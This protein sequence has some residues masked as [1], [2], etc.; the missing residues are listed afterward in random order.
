MPVTINP[1]EVEFS[2]I[3]AQGPGGQNV[4]K[5]SCAVHAR[6]DIA[7]SSLPQ[8]IKQRML[9][10]RDSRITEDGVVVIKAQQSRSLEQ[11]KEDA[12]NRLQQLVDQAADIPAV[13]RP[14]RPTRAS[15]RRR[16]DGKAR[17]GQIKALRGKV[18]D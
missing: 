11:N 13:R 4:N 1:A 17:S 2:A 16:L 5:V 8:H 14:T 6:F 10:L 18:L 12:L 7:A 9:A 15:Q 3:R